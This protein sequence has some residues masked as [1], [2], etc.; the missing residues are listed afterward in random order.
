MVIHVAQGFVERNNKAFVG[1]TSCCAGMA[2]AEP[3][4][5]VFWSL[6]VFRKEG[7]GAEV[8]ELQGSPSGG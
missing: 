5:K 2:F 4:F 6:A 3:I 8:L 7:K 1:L